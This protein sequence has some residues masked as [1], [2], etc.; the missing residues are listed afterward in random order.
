MKWRSHHSKHHSEE[1]CGGPSDRLTSGSPRAGKTVPDKLRLGDQPPGFAKQAPRFSVHRALEAEAPILRLPTEVILE[2]ASNTTPCSRACL[3]LSSKG[4]FCVI[5]DGV[6]DVFDGLQLPA[7]I[8]RDNPP[9]FVANDWSLM[10]QP[11]R[12]NFLCLLQKDSRKWLACSGYLVLHPALWF[13]QTKVAV[14]PLKRS[15]PQCRPPK[16][17]HLSWKKVP[18]GIVDLY[19]CVKF[20]QGKK[21]TLVAYLEGHKE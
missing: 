2:I 4:L 11:E 16:L 10:Y 12:W 13:G 6:S 19:P 14:W 7:E 21:R 15:W 18:R 9:C 8:P 5:S 20:I 1:K 3:A 17:E